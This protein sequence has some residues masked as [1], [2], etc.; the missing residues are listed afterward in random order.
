MVTALPAHEQ[1]P[2]DPHIAQDIS[3]SPEHSIEWGQCQVETTN[4]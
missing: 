4:Q 1:P 3:I 2:T